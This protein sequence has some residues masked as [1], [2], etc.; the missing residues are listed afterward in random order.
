MLR[1]R[2]PATRQFERCVP[3]LFLA[4]WLACTVAVLAAA[5]AWKGPPDDHR[6]A[7]TLAH[8]VGA[9]VAVGFFAGGLAVSVLSLAHAC[10][11]R[12]LD[13]NREALPAASPRVV[14]ERR[15]RLLYLGFL[16]AAAAA[17]KVDVSLAQWCLAD[18]LPRVL[19]DP[20]DA[21]AIF[22]HA[23][24]ALV[25]LAAIYLLDPRWRRRLWFVLACAALS[26]LAANGAK[27]L[28]ART[29][30]L[31]FDFEGDV[32][33]TF[34][35]WLPAGGLSQSFPSGHAATAAGLALGLAVVYPRG[36]WLFLLLAVLVA[37]QR[38]EC[39]AHFLSDVLA[40]VAASCL[41]VACCLRLGSWLSPLRRPE[42]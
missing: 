28:L 18:L 34:G 24:M 13:R 36:R 32:W 33:T 12:L 7:A 1:L 4:T 27:L 41:T 31:D 3:Y 22:G 6:G 26:G 29:R 21:C 9:A 15:L 37:C 19:R 5:T 8:R 23:M 30:P 42:G 25:V 39:G 38:L 2:L 17:L 40:G 11:W 35:Q 14:A 16:L 20:L 10:A